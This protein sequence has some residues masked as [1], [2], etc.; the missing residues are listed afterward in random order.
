MAGMN[1]DRPNGAVPVGTL[2]GGNWTASIR[3]FDLDGSHSAIYIGD[4][5][6]TTADGYLDVYAA[7]E[8]QVIG[9]C[10]GVEVNRG[11]DTK[12]EFPGYAPA[13]VA[14]TI[15]VA[16]DPF[17][18]MEMQEDGLV[19]PLELADIGANVE[20]ING[21]G[22]ATTGLSAMEIDSSSHNTTAS[23]P[24]RLVGLVTRPNNQ[25]GDTDSSKPNARWLVTFAN[26]AFLDEGI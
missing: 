11:L 3:S 9:V 14:C 2:G 7:G 23:L 4:L 12:T 16:T 24:L 17:L 13:N 1:P 19:D 22:S 6:Q 8:E 5:V 25:L 26:H 18:L 15:R 21:T 20:I 10:V